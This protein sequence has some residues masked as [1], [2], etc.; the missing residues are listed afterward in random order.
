MK[1]HT[2]VKEINT[3]I[4]SIARRGKILDHDIH[5]AG[6]SCLKHA[7]EHGDTTLL[8]KLVLAMPQGSRKHAFMEWALAYG[9]VRA[10]D[11]GNDADKAAIE[12]GRIFAKDKAKQYDEA[13]AIANAWYNFKPEPDL[14]TTF[15]V[16]KAVA[17]L[18]K[19]AT[20]AT[21]EG[22]TLE[23]VDEALKSLEALKQ[24]L[25]TQTETL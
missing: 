15:D 21:K 4:E 20:N 25:S 17:Q 9:N 2:S 24:L 8:D 14:L 22:A 11:R 1:L 7:A 3:A 12:Q 10:L 13:G 6:V 16:Q 23:G 5:R 18:I 19:R